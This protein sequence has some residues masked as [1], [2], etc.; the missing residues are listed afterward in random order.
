MG[1]E[2]PLNKAYNPEN[3]TLYSQAIK[4]LSRE[5]NTEYLD[6]FRLLAD[7]EG[8]FQDI[9]NAGDGIHIKPKEYPVIE[10]FLRCHTGS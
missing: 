6:V 2:T 1:R 4:D 5:Y 9:Y 8:Y 10:D 7:N 3:T